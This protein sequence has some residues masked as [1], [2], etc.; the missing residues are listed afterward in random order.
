MILQSLASLYTRLHETGKAPPLGFGFQGVGFVLEIDRDGNL[1]GDPIDWRD[2]SGRTPR[3]KPD[4]VPFTN[5]VDVRSSNVEPNFLVDKPA[6]VLG[7]DARTRAERLKE[8]HQGFVKLY[9]AVTHNNTDPGIE[10][11]RRFLAKWKPSLASGLKHWDEISGAHGGWLAFKLSDERQLIHH[12]EAVRDCW[13]RY[14]KEQ[15]SPVTGRSLLSN[16]PKPLQRL[17]AQFRGV[18]GAQQTGASLVSFNAP[19][20]ESFGRDGSYNAPI[21][22][23]EEFACS[24]ALKCLLASQDQRIK[25]GEAT[26]VF[27]TERDSPVEGFFKM[28]FDPGEDDGRM[29]ALKLFLEAVRDGKKPDLPD[30]DIKFFIL[31]LSPNAARLAVRFWHVSTVADISEKLGRYFRDITIRKSFD[32]EPDFPSLQQL[33]RETAPQTRKPQDRIPPPLLVGAMARS[34][35]EG[36]PFPTSL[37]P[38][39]LDRIRAD[40]G[41]I[42]YFRACLLA[43]VLR[44][45]HKQE[46]SMALDPNNK[47]RAYLLGRLFAV[48]ERAQAEAINKPGATI[49]DRFYS[50]ASATPC[51][52]FPVLLRLVQKHV[53]KAEYGG[54]RD[55]EIAAILNDVQEFPKR[56]C[57]EEQGQFA[58]GYYHQ[59]QFRPATKPQE[60]IPHEQPNQ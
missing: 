22:V 8:C 47:D 52:V 39:V 56:L 7:A 35:L 45:N 32:H 6:Y 60:E 55:R 23:D 15:S 58:L 14:F 25:I 17:Y 31:G 30:T 48:L 19:A 37:L 18:S 12:R 57:M 11:V 4:E 50:S 51:A 49:R 26:T 9:D 24:T 38:I 28:V 43:G 36:L 20:Y 1:V 40:Q 27:W 41:E 10:A 46:V 33:L 5:A 54:F 53:A 59:R 13:S 16:E 2:T 3:P 44:R 34:L 29:L 21:A 42:N